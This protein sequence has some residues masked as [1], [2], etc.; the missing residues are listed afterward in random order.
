M[1]YKILPN[2][3]NCGACEPECPNSAIALGDDIYEIAAD[4]CTECVGYHAK[5]QCAAVCPIN[6]CVAD[7]AHVESEAQLLERAK[8]LNPGKTFVGEFP[9]H[10]R[11]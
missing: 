8:K 5:P 7:P 11:K 6:V 9:S 1:S 2:C 10:F 3:N 4:H